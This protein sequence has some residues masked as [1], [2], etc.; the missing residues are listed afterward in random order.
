MPSLYELLD[1]APSAS[2]EEV[3]VAYKTKAMS[4]HPDRGGDRAAWAAIQRAYD[5]LSDLQA[6]AAYD[7]K[8]EAGGD[9]AA[10]GGTL[11]FAQ[12]FGSG[13]FDA[14]DGGQARARKGGMSIAQQLEEVQKDEE[15]M[16]ENAKTAVIAAEG[17]MSH[18][19]GFDAWL[20]NQKGMGKHGYF[21][22][23]DL[24][25]RGPMGGISP[26]EATD[27]SATP[28]P[29]LT[30]TAVTFSKHGKPEEVLG[31]ERARPLPAQLQHG[32][33]LVYMLAACI[34]DE[35]LLRVQTPLTM[36]NEFPPFNR[37][38]AKWEHLALPAV[39]GVEG[40]GIVVAAAQDVGADK[41]AT[42]AERAMFPKKAEEEE[43]QL[44]VKDW[45]IPL[46]DARLAPV[47]CWSTLCVCDSK[48]LLKVPPA[49]LPTQHFA[50]SRAL[51]TAYAAARNSAR[52]WAR[53]SRRTSLTPST[54]HLRRYRLLED[55]GNLRPGDAIIQNA[56]DLPVGQAV[57]QLCKL[58][59]IRTVNLV[60]DDDGF[61]R[62]KELLVN[63][64]ATH[65]LRDN[66]K[67]AELL[68]A[69]GSGLFPRLALDAI[70]GDAG[71]RMAIALRPGASLVLHSLSS[72]Q[73][74][75]LSP[76]L[77]MFQQVSLY[78]F[79][80]SQWV[81]DHGAPAYLQMLRTLGE[82]VQS[83][84]LR[85]FTR[86]L[87]LAD[88]AAKDDD[89]SGASG[90]S[91]P[92]R[93]A[94]YSHRAVQDEATVRQR[95]VLLFGDEA[96]AS[97]LYFE[98]QEQIRTLR[99]AAANGET[100]DFAAAALRVDPA[101]SSAKAPGGGGA[102]ARAAAARWADARAMLVELKLEQYIETFEEEEMTSIELLCDIG[103]RADGEK[104]LTEALKEMG[105]KKM[106]HRQAIVGAV[107][108]K[109]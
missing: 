51:C 109:I 84:K 62:T 92:L 90:G 42:E 87:S 1:V 7:R 65:V 16:R 47:G 15:R 19:A 45:V 95:T 30:A 29:P 41:E 107:V 75:E 98:L 67:L 93:D 56:A 12:K 11:T 34:G 52:N 5:T 59:K 104:E 79:N 63:L 89:G 60:A 33:V 31:V 13:A 49:L 100:V 108:G 82:L 72:G 54:H 24:L 22:A 69:L 26:I 88:V 64:G 91:S 97:E 102:P 21:T 61:E 20:R 32:E 66:A 6:R 36:L 3:R 35:D 103:G 25:R 4:A 43:L 18:N 44:E 40:V 39:A 99:D 17:S 76:S 2:T 96:G 50:C 57:I 105:I 74:P 23:E 80:L 14:A 38:A 71:R 81:S 46:P 94:L 37:S 48:R 9:E 101:K 68:D 83:E 106:G 77:V 55:F 70:G 28:L 53:N 78:A 58:L 8:R 27:S 10:A 85:I 86:T 73:V